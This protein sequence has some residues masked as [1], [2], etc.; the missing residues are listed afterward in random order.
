MLASQWHPFLMNLL[1]AQTIVHS[2]LP[3][4]SHGDCW[5]LQ[6]LPLSQPQLHSSAACLDSLVSDGALGKWSSLRTSSCT[7]AHRPWHHSRQQ[8]GAKKRKESVARGVWL[9]HLDTGWAQFRQTLTTMKMCWTSLTSSWLTFS[10]GI[11]TLTISL[12]RSWQRRSNPFLWCHILRKVNQMRSRGLAQLP[13][14]ISTT[15]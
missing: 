4:D 3:L 9:E 1:A 8:H 7:P 2:I 6:H 11:G 10:W 5:P 14:K 15:Y 12:M 13:F